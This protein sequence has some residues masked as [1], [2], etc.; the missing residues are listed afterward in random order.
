MTKEDQDK[1]PLCDGVNAFKYQME[2]EQYD[3]INDPLCN[4]P[5][6]C[7]YITFSA[8]KSNFNLIP[9]NECESYWEG[10]PGLTNAVNV[11]RWRI[12]GT[13]CYLR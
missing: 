12:P 3:P 10:R 9:E 6:D 4:C 7:E 2:Y 13:H 5:P 11:R 1:I 8:E